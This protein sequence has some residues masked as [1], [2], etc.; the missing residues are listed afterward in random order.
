M[1]KKRTPRTPPRDGKG[2]RAKNK[3]PRKGLN[4]R[5]RK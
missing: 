5:T 1:L 2:V 4:R 3:Q